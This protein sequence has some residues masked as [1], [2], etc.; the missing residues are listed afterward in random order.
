MLIQISEMSK[1]MSDATLLGPNFHKKLFPKFEIVNCYQN[2][3]RS[4]K[5]GNSDYDRV[6]IT[7]HVTI[8]REVRNFE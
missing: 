7:K 1:K 6:S 8:A 5:L 2:W 4:I 3:I